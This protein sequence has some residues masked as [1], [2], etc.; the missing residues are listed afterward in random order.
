MATD[1]ATARA[2]VLRD[3]C[4]EA[5]AF[6]TADEVDALLVQAY[7]ELA[8][9]TR[10]FWDWLY[11]ENLPRGFSYTAP[12]EADYLAEIDGA[13]N[14]GRANFTYED[15]RA[16]MEELLTDAQKDGPANHTCPVEATAGY[17]AEAG[18]STTI[19]ATATLPASC[20]TIDRPVWDTASI[21]VLTPLDAERRDSRYELTQGEVYGLVT[22]GDGH[23]TVRK[24]RVPAAQADTFTIDGSWGALRDPSDMG[25]ATVSGTWGIPRR[26]PGH[27]PLGTEAFGLPRRP[28]RDGKNVRVEHW[29][30]GRTLTLDGDV[31]ECPDRL[32][33]CCRHYAMSRC[34]GRNGPAQDLRL[35]K[36]YDARYRRGVARVLER[37]HRQQRAV[38]GAFGGRPMGRRSGPPTPRLPWNYGQE[39]R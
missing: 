2:R 21:A 19:P 5:Q 23:Q 28:Y 3:L 31:F 22:R 14:Y 35:A 9:V 33:V 8:R 1:L 18:A 10:C 24:V 15:E 17:L 16:L 30:E 26:L 34:L 4:D 27:H 32:V 7:R 29:R 11:L 6:W 25:T 38:V 36:H 39:L 12:C 20:H 13:L 37:M